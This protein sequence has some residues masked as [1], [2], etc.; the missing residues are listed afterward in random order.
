[1][2]NL[3]R[4]LFPWGKPYFT[5]SHPGFLG[6]CG[7]VNEKF[8]KKMWGSRKMIGYDRDDRIT[9]YIHGNL[10]S[11]LG[12]DIPIW[13]SGTITTAPQQKCKV[14]D[15]DG[16]AEFDAYILLRWNQY[17]RR[18]LGYIVL[19]EDVKMGNM[20][21]DNYIERMRVS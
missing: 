15:V 17:E 7:E 5:T 20:D 14:W 21:L 6:A 2:T 16:F 10:E 12:Y 11:Q 18:W 1:M 9:L 8:M 4:K 3:L 13:L 19:P